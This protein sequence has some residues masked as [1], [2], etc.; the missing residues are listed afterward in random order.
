VTIEGTAEIFAAPRDE[1][2]RAYVGGGIG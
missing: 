2:T 1:R